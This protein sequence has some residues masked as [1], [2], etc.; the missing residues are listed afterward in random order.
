VPNNKTQELYGAAAVGV[1]FIADADV[2]K[3]INNE[4][5]WASE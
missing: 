3:D 5:V 1:S 4:F 2:Y